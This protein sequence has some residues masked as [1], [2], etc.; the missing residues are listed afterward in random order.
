[1]CQLAEKAYDNYVR[2]KN[3]KHRPSNTP[4]RDIVTLGVRP[5][6]ILLIMQREDKLE[7][8]NTSSY[9]RATLVAHCLEFNT[10]L[11]QVPHC[12][13]WRTAPSRQFLLKRVEGWK[14]GRDGYESCCER[15]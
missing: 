8:L 10:G 4:Y 9:T 5:M 7:I 6:L 3:K 15:V 2:G 1:M 13:T 14:S 12:A 11:S